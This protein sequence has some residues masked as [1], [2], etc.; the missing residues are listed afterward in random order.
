MVNENELYNLK[1]V[2]WRIGLN[3]KRWVE[4]AGDPPYTLDD[5]YKALIQLYDIDTAEQIVDNW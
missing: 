1:Y 4:V 2:L 3:K 5:I